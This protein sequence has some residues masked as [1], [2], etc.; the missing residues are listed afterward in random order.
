VRHA[1][2]AFARALGSGSDPCSWTLVPA[3]RFFQEPQQRGATEPFAQSP[4]GARFVQAPYGFLST[5]SSVLAV[6]AD[7]KLQLRL[8][9]FVISLTRR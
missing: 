7:L 5:A 4:D 8:P 6:S 3:L 1:P 9:F 2:G